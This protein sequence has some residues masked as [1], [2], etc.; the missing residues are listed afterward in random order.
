MPERMFVSLLVCGAIGCG[1]EVG[2]LA[3]TVSGE[4]AAVS[5]FDA[6]AFDD[7]WRVDF[8]ALVVS[9]SAF[10]LR[11]ADGEEAM[12]ESDAVLVDVTEGDTT[13][14]TFEG[15][16]A[17]RW[18][19]LRYRI[20]PVTAGARDVGT[21]DPAI[22]QRMIDEGLSIYVEATATKGDLTRR[23]EWAFTLDVG[24]SHCVGA[25]GTDGIIVA[26]GAQNETQVTTHW[27]HLF[28]DSLALD[29]AGMRFDAIAAAGD[30]VITLE[31]LSSQRLA[32]LRGLDGEP[33]VDEEGA[34]VVYDPGSTPL[35]E[36]TLRGMVE[37][38]TATVGH[39]DGEGHCEYTTSF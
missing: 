33:L 26:A 6:S 17:R 13:A 25:D 11:G 7:G 38:V 19:D 34:P 3:V 31:D 10:E 2:A 4:E 32:E 8:D 1:G 28:F 24:H 16:G 21:V 29:E 35:S 39:L 22:R 30:D 12:L 36:P 14:W 27:D 5:G 37:A 20:A 15:V 18:E 23:L 9:L